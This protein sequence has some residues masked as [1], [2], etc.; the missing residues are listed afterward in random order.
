[1][2]TPLEALAD[3]VWRPHNRASLRSNEA[4]AQNQKVV[5]GTRLDS[6]NR[7][8]DKRWDGRRGTLI[9]LNA[10]GR[11]EGI[12]RL[13]RRPICQHAACLV[14]R[15]IGT[16]PFVGS[17]ELRRTVRVPIARWNGVRFA[18]RML[19]VM[20][21]GISTGI[22]CVGEMSGLVAPKQFARPEATSV[23]GG[24]SDGQHGEKANCDRPQHGS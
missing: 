10:R 2:S 3:S 23:S 17:Q 13:V 19:R 20:T 15:H 24:Q 14:K 18:G 7:A 5:R 16:R 11:C 1:M 22:A 12:A 21:P 4:V 9:G 8:E 6:Q